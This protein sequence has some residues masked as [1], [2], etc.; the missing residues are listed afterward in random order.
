MWRDRWFVAIER[1]SN[2]PAFIAIAL[3]ICTIAVFQSARHF[4]FICLDDADYVSDNP[5]V[6]SGLSLANLR[7]AFAAA[8]FSNWHPLTWL[9]HMLD[10]ALFGLH[11]GAH[12]MM[13]VLFHAAN[14]GLLFL[15]LLSM[16]RRLWRSSMVAALFAFHPLHVESVA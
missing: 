15:V 1:I 5:S 12:H 13:N 6:T 16:T 14:S 7:W 4:N 8:H 11:A 3:A 10:C 9:S 2:K